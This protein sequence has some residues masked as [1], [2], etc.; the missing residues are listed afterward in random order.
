MIPLH[1]ITAI[2][3]TIVAAVFLLFVG[4]VIKV[5]RSRP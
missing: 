5:I 2:D 4:G 3:G 1:T